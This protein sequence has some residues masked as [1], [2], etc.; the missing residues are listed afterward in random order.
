MQT[1][2][3]E[4]GGRSELGGPDG[5]D[6]VFLNGVKEQNCFYGC[7][8]RKLVV[9]GVVPSLEILTAQAEGQRGEAVVHKGQRTYLILKADHQLWRAG[10]YK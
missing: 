3:P 8:H 1:E 4:F 9:S 10:R 2:V 6:G 7:A 5:V